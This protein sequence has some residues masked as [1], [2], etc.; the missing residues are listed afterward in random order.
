MERFFSQI[1]VIRVNLKVMKYWLFLYLFCSGFAFAEIICVTGKIKNRNIIDQLSKAKSN[2]EITKAIY[3]QY[4]IGFISNEVEQAPDCHDCQI[5]SKNT[6]DHATAAKEILKHTLTGTANSTSQTPKLLF[7]PECL[8]ASHIAINADSTSTQLSCPDGKKTLNRSFCNTEEILHYQN[9]V[10]SNFYGC[11][12]SMNLPTLSPKYL[13]KKYSHESGFKPY[14][15]YSG[16]HGISQLVDEFIADLYEPERGLPFIKMVANSETPECSIARKILNTDLKSSGKNLNNRPTT[17]KA[18]SFVEI[19]DGLERNI[20]Y[21]LIGAAKIAALELK[22]IFEQYDY[23]SKYQNDPHFEELNDLLI[24]AAYGPGGR[25]GARA[26]IRVYSRKN[27]PQA[28]ITTLNSGITSRGGREV[29]RYL[30]NY[31][32]S[33]K[34]SKSKSNALASLLPNPLNT[35]FIGEQGVD[36]CINAF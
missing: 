34:D 16:G 13:F 14:Y 17:K 9:A 33:N 19:G 8:K 29:T 25:S 12:K 30:R 7:K 15:S 23:L 18:C 31:T 20:L 36:A 6:S 32:N 21:G 24:L 3:A 35:E 11:L 28:F 26:A 27:N 5:R 22:P 1:G 10:I 2:S 4:H